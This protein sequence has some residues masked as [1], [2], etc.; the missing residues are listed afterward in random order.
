MKGWSDRLPLPAGELG[1][2]ALVGFAVFSL[3]VAL[4]ALARHRTE[5]RLVL[6]RSRGETVD[7]VAGVGEEQSRLTASLTTVGRKVSSGRFSRKL[8]LQLIRA[9]FSASVAP[10]VYLG[11]K[12]VLLLIGLSIGLMGS[13]LLGMSFHVTLFLMIF[14]GCALFVIPNLFVAARRDSRMGE[15]RRRLPDAVDLLEICVSS[16]MGLDMAWNAVSEEVRRVSTSFANEMELTRLEMSLGVQR[17]QAMRHMAERTG[18]DDMSSLVALL[19]Q[20]ERFGASIIDALQTFATTMREV[21]SKRAE[22]AAEKMAVKLLFPMVL[23]IFPT[24]LIVMVGPA[25]IRIVDYML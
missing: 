19:V 5:R 4:L 15:L 8:E 9:G 11:S 7:T 17:T 14:T 2:A 21:Q 3:G 6:T 25:F 18:V 12:I 23:F 1:I 10:A 13:I 16:G 24:L 20:A 22:E